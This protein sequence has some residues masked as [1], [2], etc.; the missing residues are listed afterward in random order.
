MPNTKS[1]SSP[2]ITGAIVVAL[3]HIHVGLFSNNNAFRQ[4][5]Q[6]SAARQ[7]EKMWHMPL[8]DEFREYLKSPFADIGNIGG[9]WGGAITAAHFLKLAG[10]TRTSRICPK[11]LLASVSALSWI[12]FLTGSRGRFRFVK[13]G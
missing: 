8:D 1:A 11:A 2:A 6:A 12:W 4:Q 5:V 9:R 7:D 10:A 13:F 3:G